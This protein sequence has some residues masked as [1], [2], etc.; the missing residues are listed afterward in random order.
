MSETGKSIPKVFILESLDFDD[1]EN[2]RYEGDIIYQILK[3]SSVDCKY[4]YF[5]T[6]QEFVY[7]IQKFEESNFRY[8]HLSCHASKEGIMTTLGDS[9]LLDELTMI[10]EN[11]LDKRWLFLSACSLTNYNLASSIFSNT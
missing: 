6:K 4:H 5:I 2:S 3:M 10:L 9:V 11:V 1:E 8:L 7:F